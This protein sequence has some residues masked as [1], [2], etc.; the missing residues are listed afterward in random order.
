M[1]AGADSGACPVCCNVPQPPFRLGACPGCLFAICD[2]CVPQLGESCP[3]CRSSFSD[4]RDRGLRLLHSVPRAGGS[5]AGVMPRRLPSCV[6][7]S[8]GGVL[9]GSDAGRRLGPVPQQPGISWSPRLPA[10]RP[11]EGRAVSPSAV[12]RRFGAE[13]LQALPVQVAGVTATVACGQSRNDSEM[14]PQRCLTELQPSPLTPTSQETPCSQGGSSSVAQLQDA[15]W[16]LSFPDAHDAARGR[17]TADPVGQVLSALTGAQDPVQLKRALHAQNLGHG[18][19]DVGQAHVTITR[20]LQEIILAQPP[21]TL[22]DLAAGSADFSLRYMLP[23]PHRLAVCALSAKNGWSK[24][25]LLQGLL[26]NMGWLEHHGTR[27]V[28]SQGA[29]HRRAATIAAFFAGPPSAR[30]SS[31]HT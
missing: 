3:Q 25:G 24:E 27:I 2:I 17:S 19:G 13:V 31:L 23:E 1:Q 30:K 11:L 29:D 8:E 4:L 14:V 12:R 26:V 9:V 21:P 22:E 16:G 18:F 15:E 20:W 10:R 5:V 6:G 28:D 7:D